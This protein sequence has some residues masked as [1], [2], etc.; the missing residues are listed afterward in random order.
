MQFKD[1][2]S[3]LVSIEKHFDVE[4]IQDSDVCIWPLIRQTLWFLLSQKDINLKNRITKQTVD[5]SFTRILKNWPIR[6]KQIKQFFHLFKKSNDCIETVFFSR[7]VYLQR[8]GDCSLA[9]DR[10]VDPLLAISQEFEEV[11]KF[12]IGGIGNEENLAYSANELY[13]H[14][15]STNKVF[16]LELLATLIEV[17]EYAELDQT[18]FINKFKSNYLL[19]CKWFV[20]GEKL[21]KHHSSIKTIYLTSWYFPDM[22]GLIFAAKKRNIKVIDIQHGQQGKFQGLYSWWTKAPKGGYLLMPDKFWCW[23]QQSVDNIIQSSHPNLSSMPFLGGYPWMQFY[24]NILN[25][26]NDPESTQN[27]II[28]FTL[29]APDGEHKNVIPD[30]VLNYLKSNLGENVKWIFRCHPNYHGC[31]EYVSKRL[32]AINIKKYIISSGKRALYED[33]LS[34]THHITACSTCCYEADAFGIPTMLFGKD[35]ITIYK[36]EIKNNTFSWT[37]GSLE[38]I[39]IWIKADNT[40]HLNSGYIIS[41]LDLASEMLKLQSQNDDKNKKL[42]IN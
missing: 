14:S 33:M 12:Y 8:V 3:V 10:V 17:A 7:K 18:T 32:K 6:V 15:F 21:F 9:Y 20:T 37:S 39:D 22:M 31:I 4:K 27:K 28:L 23:G 29:Q 30:F 1:I 5:N 34:A 16:S 13:M 42:S 11:K 35:A 38:D 24:K 41:S 19:F 36:E 40:S 26:M 2:C 25:K